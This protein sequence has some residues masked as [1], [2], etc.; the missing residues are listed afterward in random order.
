MKYCS[1]YII[2]IYCFHSGDHSKINQPD[3]SQTLDQ[4]LVSNGVIIDI[5]SC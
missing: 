1:L 3:Q 2:M 5:S 4:S